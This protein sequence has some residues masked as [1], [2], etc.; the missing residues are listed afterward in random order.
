M[1]KHLLISVL[2]I[3]GIQASQAQIIPNL[4]GNASAP[5]AAGNEAAQTSPM[6]GVPTATV[7]GPIPSTVGV[8]VNPPAPR[9]QLV[10]VSPAPAGRMFGSQLFG[11]TFRGTLNHGFNPDYVL[12]IGD[13]LIVRMWGGFNFEGSLVVD[14]QGNIFLPNVGPVKVAGLKSG[15]LNT[16]LDVAVRR[17][18]KANTFVYAALDASQPVKVYVTGFVRQPGLYN[19]LAGDSPVAFLDKAGGVDPDRGSYLD[20]TVKRG[21]QVRKRVN[22]YDFLLEGKLDLVQFQDG[23]VIV[24]GPRRHTFSVGG[25]VFNAYDFEFDQ[26]SIPLS[27]A[28]AMA[29]PKPGATHVSVV[30]RQGSEK[31]SEYYLL[32]EAK[33]VRIEDGDLVNVTADR[34]QG[35]IQ[36]RVEGAH[37]GEHAI[38]LPYGSKLKDVIAQLK[39]NS[40]SRVDAIQIYRKSVQVRQKEMLELALRKVEEAALSA[41]SKTVEEANLRSREADLIIKFVERARQVQPKGQVVLDDKVRD[42]TLLEDGDTIII[43][44][45]TSLVMVHGEVLFPNAISWR[46]GANAEDY[47]A[48][49]GG[50]T[51]GADTSKVV[52][53][54]QNGAARLA[55]VQS[56]FFRRSGTSIQAGDEIIVLPK[57]ETKSVEVT[58]A[59]TQILYQIAFTAK[60]AFGL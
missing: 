27:A 42:E 23:D 48:A 5:G 29:K 54:A 49:A 22:L 32:A 20:V 58:R 28:L 50:Y 14:Q 37:S 10:V 4:F 6:P 38:V 52:V 35:T 34:Y 36:V 11:G 57:I 51:Q 3:A 8:T 21:S 39:P 13:R 41:R 9:D 24:V 26:A 59:I 60:V 15:E 40:M 18:F 2:L 45:R 56:T 53:I 33:H 55:D 43:P 30:R 7:P 12:A 1:S 25:E 46:E 47:I 44:E 19:G 31:R 17:V 16:Q